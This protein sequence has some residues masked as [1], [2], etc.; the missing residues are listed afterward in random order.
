MSRSQFELLFVFEGHC[1][2]V[3]GGVAYAAADRVGLAA[4]PESEG[5]RLP[6]DGGVEVSGE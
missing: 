3:G 6:P 2:G 4:P 5:A 1:G